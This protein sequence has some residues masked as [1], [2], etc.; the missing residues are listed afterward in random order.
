MQL[1]DQ[2]LYDIY[3]MYYVPFWQTSWF[4]WCIVVTLG[5]L[6]A[7]VCV[8]TVYFLLRKKQKV[9]P[10]S[11]AL[12]QLDMI[13]TLIMKNNLSS[14]DIK[15]F[16]FKMTALLKCYIAERYERPL[17]HYTDGE[18]IGFIE[19]SDCDHS[20]KKDIKIIYDHGTMVKFADEKT[21]VSNLKNDA[22]RVR[23]IIQA[24]IPHTTYHSKTTIKG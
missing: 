7:I 19:Q 5:C 17:Q 8:T 15:D 10:W 18:F 16:Y 11:K 24:T 3:G 20:M 12:S 13:D 23:A 1:N 2:G 14:A 9:T 4:F 6:L 21:A 22:A